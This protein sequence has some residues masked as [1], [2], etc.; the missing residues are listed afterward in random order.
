MQALPVQTVTINDS[1]VPKSDEYTATI[2]SRR[3]ATMSPQVDGNITEILAKS[4]DRVKAG[5]ILIRDRPGEAEGDARFADRDRTAKEGALRLQQHRGRAAAQALRGRHDQPRRAAT[6]PS[7]T[8][9]TPR[10]TMSRP[11]RSAQDPGKAAWLLPHPR[12][13]RWH[14]GRYSGA[15]GRLCLTD[16]DADDGGREPRFR[17]LYLHSDRTQRRRCAPAFL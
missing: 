14:R 17:G 11:C 15:S 4:G 9:A 2:K 1:P 7:R 13:V 6:R 8:T 5:Q 3:S 16:D 10:P 12:T